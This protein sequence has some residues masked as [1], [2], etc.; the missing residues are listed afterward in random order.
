MM[1]AGRASPTT[2]SQQN[3]HRMRFKTAVSLFACG[4][5]V[6]STAACAASSSS[7]KSAA[8]DGGS[9]VSSGGLKGTPIK[10]AIINDSVAPQLGGG[11][12]ENAAAV[13]A[14]VAGVNAAGGVNGR[15][16]EVTTCDSKGD[17]NLV[18]S[19]ARTVV[20][21]KDVVA[22]VGGETSAGSPAKV[23]KAGGVADFGQFAISNDDF[24]LSNSFPIMGLPLGVIECAADYAGDLAGKGGKV[25]YV[26]ISNP[27]VSA[28][29]PLV[30]GIVAKT[31]ATVKSHTSFSPTSSDLSPTVASGTNGADV[32][33]FAGGPQ[34]L[35]SYLRAAQSANSKTTTVAG[36]DLDAK[37]LEEAKGVANGVR[38]CLQW[39]P[40]A[41]KTEGSTMFAAE[42]KG[43]SFDQ[44]ETAINAWLA[45]H[46]L[47][48][49]MKTMSGTIDRT[50]VLA[51]IP[52]TSNLT[53][54]GLS[55]PVSF[56]KK[57]TGL[58]GHFPQLMNRVA[59][60]GEI[61]DGKSTLVSETPYQG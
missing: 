3:G 57:F 56:N 40:L 47:A 52:T 50:T 33:Q 20:A 36:L 22:A 10:I 45:V 7:G 34:N 44:N 54:Y 59:Y 8:S 4:M 42:T 6:V 16:L 60:R 55:T 23:L 30:D 1:P 14:A 29:N 35:L 31:G 12:P 18:Q 17:P 49:I 53:T 13:K 21:D 37:Q 61:K 46:V 2:R 32:V 51:K 19:C 41:V 9:S 24:T 38:T 25:G 26:Y 11:F 43:T 15:P 28:L 39:K 58:G 27:G 5:A 48:N